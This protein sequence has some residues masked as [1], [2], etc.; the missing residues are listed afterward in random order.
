MTPGKRARLFL[1]VQRLFDLVQL[2][3]FV[4]LLTLLL[5]SARVMGVAF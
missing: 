1:H 3:L 2:R 5:A 4:R